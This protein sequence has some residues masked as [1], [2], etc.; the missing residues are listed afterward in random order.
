MKIDNKQ[1]GPLAGK[2]DAGRSGKAENAQAQGLQNNLQSKGLDAKSKAKSLSN[3][4]VSERAQL[5]AK[6][7][8]IASQTAGV[9]EA[10]VARLQKMIDEGNYKVDADK[11]ADRLLEEHMTIPD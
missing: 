4:D 8:N 3:V 7:K 5:M 6:A 1:L 9:D 11:V 10:K 2:V